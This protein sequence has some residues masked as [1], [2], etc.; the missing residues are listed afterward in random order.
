MS[1]CFLLLVLHGVGGVSRQSN[2]RATHDAN[3]TKATMLNVLLRCALWLYSVGS[4]MR[5]HVLATRGLPTML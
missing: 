4:A 1:V 3:I 5:A 2:K